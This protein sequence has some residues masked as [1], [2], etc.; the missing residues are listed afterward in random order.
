MVRRTSELTVTIL[1]LVASRRGVAAP[2]AWAVHSYLEKNYV[3][4]RRIRKNGLFARL[5]GATTRE[6]AATAY[7][8][9]FS[10]IMRR[11]GFGELRGIFPPKD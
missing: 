11:V 5:Y 2:P 9:E 8:K 10:D 1:Q 7:I 3:I 4:C 6:S